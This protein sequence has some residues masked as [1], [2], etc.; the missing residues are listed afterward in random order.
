MPTAQALYSNTT[1]KI[2]FSF[3]LDSSINAP[4][5]FKPNKKYSDLSGFVSPYTDPTSKLQ[6]STAEEFRIIQSF[7]SDIVSGY[8]ALR[9]AQTLI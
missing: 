8:L 5:S 1:N 7:P 6:Y 3:V 2:L 4:P 9:R